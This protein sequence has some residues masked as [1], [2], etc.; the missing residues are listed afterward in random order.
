LIIVG[1]I[2]GFVS[3]VAIPPPAKAVFQMTLEQ[4]AS[5]NPVGVFQRSNVAFFRAAE[6]AFKSPVLIERTLNALGDSEVSPDQLDGIGKKLTFERIALTPNTPVYPGQIPSNTYTGS[7]TS[8]DPDLA[9]KFLETHVKLYLDSEIEK[10]LKV[11][12]VE[13]DFLTQ[14][15]TKSQKELNRTDWELQDFKRKN[16]DALPQQARQYY[17]YLFDLQKRESDAGKELAK[18]SAVL[19]HDVTRMSSEE[20]LVTSRHVDAHP[21]KSAIAEKERLLAEAQASGKGN[22]HPDVVRLLRELGELQGLEKEAEDNKE[23]EEEKSIN[24]SYSKSRD[25][26]SSAQVNARIAAIEAGRLK[27]DL[28]R[29]KGV[30]ERLPQLEAEHGELQR[31]YDSAKSTYTKLEDELKKSKLQLELER[32]AAVA[33]YDIISPPAIEYTPPLKNIAI[34]LG[35]G[36]GAAFGVALLQA[37]LRGLRRL[38]KQKKKST[39]T[40]LQTR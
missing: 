12:R 33:R 39:E 17:D 19:Q 38:K 30:V 6:Q 21:Y 27:K 37:G 9:V 36:A 40:A 29:I 25:E 34:R 15:M 22:Q 35:I 11:I 8:T 18:S 24:P 4:K 20:R 5:E 2:G 7:Y 26:L 13:V 23:N 10:T 1:A 14:E 31:Q 16:I 32:A 3:Y 28:S